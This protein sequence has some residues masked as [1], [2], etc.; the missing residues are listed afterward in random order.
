MTTSYDELLMSLGMEPSGEEGYSRYLVAQCGTRSGYERHRR[1]G[2]DACD[3]CRAANAEGKRRRLYAPKD[4][5]TL[6]PIDHGTHTGARRHRYRGE[7]PCPDCAAAY[8]VWS[9]ERKR[10]RREAKKAAKR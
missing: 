8:R 7:R 6:P 1:Q 5:E 4:P 3:A 9:N 2:E 10:R